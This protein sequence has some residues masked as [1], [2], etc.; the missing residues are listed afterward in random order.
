MG[1]GCS[2]NSCTTGKVVTQEISMVKKQHHGM[3]SPLQT[4]FQDLPPTEILRLCMGYA[5]LGEYMCRQQIHQGEVS[6]DTLAMVRD[7][8]K[9]T[10]GALLQMDKIVY[11]HHSHRKQHGPD[12]GTY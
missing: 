10:V 7:S 6:S 3:L 4:Q 2:I 12:R 8:M 1:N 9:R 5:G 11:E